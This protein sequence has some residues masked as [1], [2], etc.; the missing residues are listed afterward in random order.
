MPTWA[1]AAMP[2][3]TAVV[4]STATAMP[5]LSEGSRGARAKQETDAQCSE[6]KRTNFHCNL[7]PV[8]R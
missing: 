6:Q 4:T 1:T 8:N 5:M 2:T 3:S 7:P